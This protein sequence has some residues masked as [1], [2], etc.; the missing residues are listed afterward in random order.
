MTSNP[1][2]IHGHDGYRDPAI[3]IGKSST[4]SC[5]VKYV[6][7]RI[8]KRDLIAFHRTVQTFVSLRPWTRDHTGDYTK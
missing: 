3:V 1:T 5:D 8:T 4:R 2:I 6:K 7:V